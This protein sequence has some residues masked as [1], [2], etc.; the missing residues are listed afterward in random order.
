MKLLHIV[1]LGEEE[2]QDE[3]NTSEGCK[4]LKDG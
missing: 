4:Q 1:V 3:K 2:E